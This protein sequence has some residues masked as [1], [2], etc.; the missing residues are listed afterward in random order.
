MKKTLLILTLGI[1]GSLFP[2]TASAAPLCTSV[3]STLDLF[4]ALG[5][6]GCE[7]NG[8]LFSDFNYSYSVTNAVNPNRGRD[9][10][11]SAVLVTL[12]PLNTE[13]S[14]G[15]NWTT[16][17]SQTS[18][19]SL[20]YDVSSVTQE[21]SMLNSAFTQ[22]VTLPGMITESASCTGGSCGST[23]FT[24]TSSS[25]GLTPGPLSISNTA[26]ENSQ[27]AAGSGGL[28]HLSIIDN[29]FAQSSAP[30]D[31]PEPVTT[32]LMGAGLL[33]LAGLRRFR[34]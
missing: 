1:V 8:L 9:V 10:P 16:T 21:V 26:S 4:V 34:V 6:G 32:V 13:W 7:M 29:Q 23:D 2:C 18:T 30:A 31:A 12:T 15:G 25:I 14:F 33:A 19:L 27:S 11:A 17:G 28:V 24:N 3:G 20:T 5:S 22:S